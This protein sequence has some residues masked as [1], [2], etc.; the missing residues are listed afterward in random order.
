M[1]RHIKLSFSLENLSE[2]PP[3]WWNEA[4]LLIISI[5][6]P[7]GATF[8]SPHLKI[9]QLSDK[10]LLPIV[11]FV[12]AEQC[13]IKL[14]LVF[15]EKTVKKNFTAIMSFRLIK[16]QMCVGKCFSFVSTTHVRRKR[17]KSETLRTT[18]LEGG[19]AR[20]EQQQKVNINL[21]NPIYMTAFDGQNNGSE[22]W[23]LNNSWTLGISCTKATIPGTPNVK[24]PIRRDTHIE[25]LMARMSL[26]RPDFNYEKRS[27]TA[28]SLCRL[29][30]LVPGNAAVTQAACDFFVTG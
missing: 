7:H 3:R 12:H 22:T 24:K 21:T 15:V 2:T 4:P 1:I 29:K 11:G 13:R 18:A 5:F 25:A 8:I 17:H 23:N 20:C 19:C 30:I 14:D 28:V 26:W 10:R 16:M 6:R 9:I 27:V